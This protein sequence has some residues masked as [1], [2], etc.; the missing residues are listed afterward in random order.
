MDIFYA[1]IFC[2]V[3]MFTLFFLSQKPLRRFIKLYKEKI[4][5]DDPIWPSE[6]SRYYRDKPLQVFTDAPRIIW[7]RYE[8][9]WKDYKNKEVN[10]A[11]RKASI[12]Y[13]G[14][15]LLILID[16]FILFPIFFGF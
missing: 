3:P 11:A 2:I 8:I 4:D 16:L 14:M 13:F 5:P 12:Y 9:L 7:R 10:K 15:I 6:M 1:F